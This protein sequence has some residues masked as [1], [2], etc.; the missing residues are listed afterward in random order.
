MSEQFDKPL[1]SQYMIRGLMVRSASSWRKGCLALLA[2][3]SALLM[4]VQPASSQTL[5]PTWVLSTISGNGTN[6]DE[7][8]GGPS[9]NAELGKP[10]QAVMDKA[11]NL[12]ISEANNIIRK[13]SADGVI[14]TFAGTSSKTGAY[15]GD[16]GPA[17]N[18]LLN[19]PFGLALDKD[20][21][22]LIAD[23]LNEIIRKVNFASGI[24]TTIA[25]TQGKTGYTGDGGPA[26]N[27]TL[28]TPYGI[29][30]DSSGN[31]YIADYANHVVRKVDATG[32]ISTFAGT[33]TSGISG[34][35]GPAINAELASPWAVSADAVG[36]IYISDYAGDV[37]RMVDTAGTIH[38]IAGTA[39]TPG[40]SGDG[41]PAI[42]AEFTTP[43]NAISDGLGNLY[44]A[45]EGNHLIRW[46]DANGI[47]HTIAGTITAK[48]TGPTGTAGFDGDGSPGTAGELDFP[49]GLA[50]DSSNNLYS[51]DASN[52]RIRRLS[53]NTV[54]PATAV[55]TSTAQNLFVQSSTAVT[56]NTAVVSP[57]A[58]AEFM[59]GSLSGCSLGAPLVANTPCAVP[60]TFQPATPGLQTAQI[61]FT[62]GSG[63]VSSIGLSGIGI[64]PQVNFSLAAISTIAGTGTA[65]SAGSSGSAIGAQV[66]APR[67][68]VI[69]SAGNV[70]FAD[71]GNNIIR[72]IDAVTG[73]ISTVAG[74]G[75]AGY[76]GDG[77]SATS[78]QLRSPAK[79]IVDAAGNLYIA[80]TGNNV[81]RYV[82]AN[83]GFI[84]TI[85]GT[86]TP[87]YTGDGGAATSATLN[88]P[89]GLAIDIGGHIYVADTGNSAIRYF[90]KGGPIVTLTGTGSAG[91]YGD[92]GNALGASL[93]APQAVALDQ[94]G[95]V[96]I[97]D[98]GNDVVRVISAQ[99][100]ISTF[101][102]KYGNSSNAGD[103]GAATIATLDQPSD[104]V[105]DAAGDLYIAA[106]GQLRI[107]N[108]VGIISTLAGT[109][110]TGSYSGE[111]GAAT[112][113]ILPAPVG[114]LML[115]SAGDIV[116]ADTAANRLL[117]VSSATPM[118]LNMGVQAPGTTGSAT[119]FNVLNTGNS[120]LNLSGIATTAGF[121]LQTGDSLACTAT[122]S[123]T[124][125]QSCS[126]SLVFSPAASADG[127]VSG[128]LT[129]TD[130]ALNGTG[131]TQTFALSGSTHVLANTT[132]SIS[133]LPTSP[134]YGASV[135]ITATISNGISPT[136]TVNFTVNGTPIGTAS[137]SNGHAMITLPILPAGVVQIG[138]IYAGDAKNSSSTGSAGVSIQ[139]A[140]LT[141]SAT[142]TSMGQGTSLP[143]FTYTVTGFVNGDTGS[144]VT[145]APA[146]TTTATS[147][148]PQGAYPIVISTG[149][150]AA[151]NYSFT[152]VNGALTVGP[153]PTP[154]FS[155]S[156]TPTQ[157]TS[158]AG[159][160]YIAT[161]TLTP[162]YGYKGTVQVSC[163][164]APQG[165]GCSTTGPLTGDGSADPAG[166]GS[167]VW[168]QIQISASNT[169]ASNSPSNLQ[170]VWLAL[171]VPPWLFGIASSR[172]RK[173]RWRGGLLS[174]I[175]LTLL[176]AGMTS[177]S[178]GSKTVVN[179][180][181]LVTIMA[182]DTSAHMTH[183]TT[184][185]LTLQ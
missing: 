41:G 84:S 35:G 19:A 175:V 57:A 143:S 148:S 31:I 48:S 111:G 89:Q 166:Q 155:L 171:G 141:V 174:L 5:T 53:M 26:T 121:I 113:A 102:G 184:L 109:S 93:N 98:T 71:S 107:V 11:G 65:G 39:K 169:M 128:T 56:P 29:C 103:G 91:Y 120:T 140:T 95:N 137:L 131:V 164:S 68:G 160:P 92:G 151:T 96:Y 167:P 101:A 27:A 6:A 3:A 73:K 132:T 173:S 125:G 77:A 127:S 157:A 182:T 74:V 145:G 147:T 86:G 124:P 15:A 135:T 46:I 22:L 1:S 72:R 25:G 78:A 179:G 43:H 38:A 122:T 42:S 51:P 170:G 32:T 44:I 165:L 37:I 17:I 52:Y 54:L 123:L 108:A 2:T 87:G 114:N 23:E 20:G 81:I 88:H 172:G 82:S 177:C 100:Q 83:T 163:T 13:I 106:G 149:T 14:S 62:D 183:S 50:I 129:L 69:D 58:P 40:V 4:S 161:L 59:L 8:D 45:D 146:E 180:T 94:N 134:V 156:V 119:T 152:F 118:P 75:T 12:Y 162:I 185:T 130:N 159:Y 18:A 70:Y 36:N 67:G 61:A 115:D 181:Y 30:A 16:N 60:I 24:I 112:S 133:A 47:I 99:N 116:L 10:Y 150:L 79:V 138:A 85:A 139:P 136:G 105:L 176:T 34:D 64:A 117:K 126:V 158:T 21:N 76:A 55:G 104:V 178:A 80:D 154:D 110:A 142:N 49:Y 66:S 28:H 144:A 97:A 153:P 33:G 90:G 7:G 168:T 9:T 63:D